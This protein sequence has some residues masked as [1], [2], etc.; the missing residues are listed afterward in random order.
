MPLPG[1]RKGRPSLVG[2]MSSGCFLYALVFADVLVRKH[3]IF[4]IFRPNIE[5]KIR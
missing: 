2:V 1:K 5:P 4:L 3:N